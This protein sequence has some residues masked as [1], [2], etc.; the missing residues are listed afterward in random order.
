MKVFIHDLPPLIGFIIAAA[1][2]WC[3]K[4]FAN[5]HVFKPWANK[6]QKV[7]EIKVTELPKNEAEH[8]YGIAAGDLGAYERF[9][10]I[11]CVLI[12]DFELVVAWVILK[13]FQDFMIGK[14]KEA[15]ISLKNYKYNLFAG[16][17]LFS[18]LIGLLWGFVA[19]FIAVVVAEC[20][21]C[22]TTYGLFPTPHS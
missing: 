22:H 12:W 3:T 14:T 16:G 19:R 5:S 15:N 4:R 17:S 10:F 8:P 7:H 13:E 6:M 1:A 2:M 18:L 20:I 11:F 21:G 9:I